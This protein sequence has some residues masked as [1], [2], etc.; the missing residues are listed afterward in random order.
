MEALHDHPETGLDLRLERFGAAVAPASPAVPELDF[1][2]RI[3]RLR[4]AD[5]GRLEE[6]LVFY[7]ALGVDPWL[8]LPPEPELDE[9]AAALAR[10]GARP[11]GFQSVLYGGPSTAVAPA[12]ATRRV[13][14]DEA[15]VAARVLLEGHGV[16]AKVLGTH[17]PPLAA[18]V[19]AVGGAL[20]VAHVDGAPAA[21]AILTRAGGAGYLA[22]A[23]TLP[24]FRRRGCQTALI[25]ARVADAAAAGCELVFSLAEFAS[26]SQRNL[27][28]AGLSLAYTKTVLRL[29]PPDGRPPAATA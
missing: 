27:E 7:G 9:I 26:P 3:E 10:A 23:A 8:E 15:G 21:A 2:N 6:I 25:A 13:G 29:T 18:A 16:P 28:R 20:Y 22:L 24:P 1:V 4:P 17:A 11:V 19:E 14:A 5:V 12:V